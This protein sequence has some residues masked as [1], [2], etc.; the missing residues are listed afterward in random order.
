M[1]TKTIFDLNDKHENPVVIEKALPEFRKN[2]VPYAREM[3]T[4]LNMSPFFE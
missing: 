1:K 2:R 4:L 3:T